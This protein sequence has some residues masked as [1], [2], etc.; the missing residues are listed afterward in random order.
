MKNKF[1]RSNRYKIV[2]AVIC[3]II[4][5]FVIL[6]PGSAS[7]APALDRDGA[8][9]NYIEFLSG[10]GSTEKIMN[11][12]WL[13][14]KLPGMGTDETALPDMTL[15]EAESEGLLGNNEELNT[16]NS[17]QATQY[18]SIA[19]Q[20]H[21]LV[22]E[23]FGKDAWDNVSFTLE[24]IEPL[25]GKLGFRLIGSGEIVSEQ[26]YEKVMQTYW[27]KVAKEEGVDYYDIFLREGEPV[28]NMQNK[29]VDLI[30]EYSPNQPAELTTIS[31]AETYRVNLKFNN[32][33][34]S[35]EGYKD[36]NF[37][38]DNQD[39]DWEVF[40]GLTW[41]APNMEEPLVEV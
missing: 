36:F 32:L 15:D 18:N 6:Q 9:N 4:G 3:L 10:A 5:S 12:N 37:V 27:E 16:F 24:P 1:L 41:T 19:V 28:E 31:D 38:I 33:K 26:E 39:G 14:T 23:Q 21:N 40:N 8:A 34:E 7:A 25:E 35:D 20:Q 2:A 29:R 17:A 11:D 30:S 13:Y 22:V